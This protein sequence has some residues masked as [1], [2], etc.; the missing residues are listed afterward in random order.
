MMAKK[1]EKTNA[2]RILDQQKIA[3]ETLTYIAEDGAVDGISVA[4][5]IGENVE[6]VFKT[7]VATNAKG[8]YFVFVIPVACELDL[9]AAAKV[10][11]E[12]KIEMIAVKD[13]L[14]LTGYIRGGCSPVGMKKL[15]PTFIEHTAKEYEQII[16]SAGKIGLQI[17]L[18]PEALSQITKGQFAQLS[19]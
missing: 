2:I 5:K 4:A 18:A 16:I 6:Q 13:L 1:I 14:P 9:K 15:F 17:K 3:Y 12:K 8:S 19:K 10:A 11:K 7:L